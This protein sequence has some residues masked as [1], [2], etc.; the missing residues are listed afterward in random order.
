VLI[1]PNKPELEQALADTVAATNKGAQARLLTWPLEGLAD[2]LTQAD[3]WREWSCGE[4]DRGGQS[5]S[6]MA[7]AWWSDHAGRKHC[8]IVGERGKYV[9][10]RLRHLRGSPGREHSTLALVYPDVLFRHTSGGRSEW[11]VWCECGAL[12][13]TDELGWMGTCCGPCH[14]RREEGDGPVS[15]WPPPKRTWHQQPGFSR[16]AFSRAG[17]LLFAHLSSTTVWAPATGNALFSLLPSSGALSFRWAFFHPLEEALLTASDNGQVRQIDLKTRERRKVV[18][19]EGHISTL[20]ISPDGRRLAL[21]ETGLVWLWDVPRNHR[22]RSHG[23]AVNPIHEV[24][25]S[26][27]GKVLAGIESYYNEPDAVVLWDVTSG[28][29]R[30][31]RSCGPSRRGWGLAWSPCGEFLA[32]CTAPQLDAQPGA[33]Q[34][35]PRQAIIWDIAGRGGRNWFVQHTNGTSCVAWS[36]DGRFLASGGDDHFVGLW[37]TTSARELAVLGWHRDSVQALAWSPDGRFLA[38]SS[39]GGTVKLWPGAL[40]QALVERAKVQAP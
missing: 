38:S 10:S 3:G 20:A 8:R 39:I 16:L 37:D 24:A 36:P 30:A 22:L 40:P 11:L 7:L 2:L 9:L 34:E 18:R 6:V 21:V 27:D 12:G 26:P 28:E 13:R 19:T 5:R 14:D 23:S 17:A 29:E 35:G 15:A 33:L 1:A 32:I 25:F 31:R 4:R